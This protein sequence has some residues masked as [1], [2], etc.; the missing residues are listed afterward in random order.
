MAEGIITEEE[1]T[2][3]TGAGLKD[4]EW[5]VAKTLLDANAR[6]V[7]AFEYHLLRT[8]REDA[9]NLESVQ[10]NI[11]QAIDEHEKIIENLEA[12]GQAVAELQDDRDIDPSEE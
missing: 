10:S 12:V 5:A 3:S 7:Q 1:N 4:L 6:T 8:Y 11:R 2:E 9:S